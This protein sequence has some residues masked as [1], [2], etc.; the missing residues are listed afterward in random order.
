MLPQ[1]LPVLLDP[2]QGAFGA[3]SL[4][5]VHNIGAAFSLIGSALL[6][7]SIYKITLQTPTKT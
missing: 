5:A 2:L 6:L 3:T 1:M 4:S 7:Y